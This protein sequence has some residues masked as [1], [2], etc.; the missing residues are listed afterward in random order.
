MWIRN[1]YKNINHEWLDGRTII[2]GHTPAKEKEIRQRVEK[3][4]QAICIDNGCFVDFMQWQC[5]IAGRNTLEYAK[6]IF[7][8]LATNA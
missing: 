8:L 3:R 1:W 6:D 4:E 2:H 7:S 5:A